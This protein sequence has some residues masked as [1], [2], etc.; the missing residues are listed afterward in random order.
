M[1][2]AVRTAID[3]GVIAPTRLDRALAWLP[4]GGTLEE[5]EWAPRHRVISLVLWLHTPFIAIIGIANR[6]RLVEVLVDTGAI[7]TAATLAAV[8]PGRAGKTAFVSLGLLCSS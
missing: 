1:T 4:T 5:A 3:R 8:A 2:S 7:V 6:Q